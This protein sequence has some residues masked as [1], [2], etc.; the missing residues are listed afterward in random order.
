MNVAREN[1][2]SP[3]WRRLQPAA[4]ATEDDDDDEKRTI[5]RT[6]YNFLRFYGAVVA[7][8]NSECCEGHRRSI[9]SLET[10]ISNLL[11]SYYHHLPLQPSPS[12]QLTCDLSPNAERTN[13]LNI[14]PG[15]LRAAMSSILLLISIHQHYPF[16]AGYEYPFIRR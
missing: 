2:L 4:S 1:R 10:S 14:Q 5:W 11:C 7:F 13:E 12:T 3:T 16:Q 9:L 8:F 6:S 15:L